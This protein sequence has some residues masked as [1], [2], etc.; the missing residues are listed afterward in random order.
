MTQYLIKYGKKDDNRLEIS[1]FID[2]LCG[3]ES[4]FQLPA[5]RPG[6]YEL[7]NFAQNMFCL[8]AKN[9]SGSTLN[10]Y[11]ITKDRWKI[12]HPGATTLSLKYTYAAVIKNAGGTF[13]T[14]DQL[15]ITPVNCLIYAE[16]LLGK[17]CQISLEIPIEFESFSAIKNGLCGSFYE[18][19]SSPIICGADIC[20]KTLTC[21]GV[22]FHILFQGN[23]SP[24]WTKITQDYAKF[25]A[26]QL[27]I[28]KEFVSTDYYF[29]NLIFEE[30]HYHGVEHLNSTLIALGPDNAFG[31]EDFYLNLL[32]IS[33]HELFH[34]WNICR[35]RPLEL[36]PYDY[37]QETYFQTGYIAEGITTYYGDYLL[38]RAKVVTTQQCLLDL[39]ATIS[40][41]L[42]NPA[43][44]QVS[45][46]ESSV[47]LWLDGY[48][49]G[50]LGRKVSIYHK[51]AA[52]AFLLDLWIR[53]TT[54][55][56]KSL[57]NVML[58]MWQKHGKVGIGYSNN[59]Y[60]NCIEEVVQQ[61]VEWYFEDYV[62]GTIPVENLLGSLLLDFGMI[63]KQETSLDSVKWT[64]YLVED[65]NDSKKENF[66]KWFSTTT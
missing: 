32:G 4:F 44:H 3:E 23:V 13:K 53:K 35:I 37:S 6:R 64:I 8:S 60:K 19:A 33:S 22:Q 36:L 55:N 54:Q 7:G 18:L 52:I 24:D 9:Q 29:L 30:D 39:S 58:L 56:T 20:E 47:D 14:P 25:I 27:S 50:V 57:D 43:R 45:V 46:A 26:E 28:F 31:H 21:S 61:N 15:V 51:G 34:Y 41:H 65:M 63:L 62:F 16:H 5:W 10:C 59:D 48:K 1:L 40:R 49:T 66:D 11:K 2:D 38:G 17:P 12:E 42:T